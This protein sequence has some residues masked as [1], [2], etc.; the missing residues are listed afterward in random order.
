LYFFGGNQESYY[1]LYFAWHVTRNTDSKYDP[2][3]G[4][5]NGSVMFFY[6][7]WLQNIFCI[8]R[9][10]SFKIKFWV[11]NTLVASY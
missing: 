9:E 8:S 7:I 2:I 10:H 5:K 6:R 4:R 1:R 11:R 3:D